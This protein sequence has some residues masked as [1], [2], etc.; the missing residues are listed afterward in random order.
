MEDKIKEWLLKGG[1]PLEMRF[2]DSLLK[3]EFEVAQSVYYQ[4][5]DTDKFRETDIIASKY[6][7]INKIWTHIAFVIE[8]KKSTDKPWIVLK[9]DKVINH[10]G[11][12]L[13]VFKTRNCNEFIR[14][15]K[16]DNHY[17]SDLFFKN[18]RS[19]G[20]SVQTAFNNGT[21]K[22]FEAIQSVTKACEYF[23]NKLNERRNTAAFYFPVILIEGRLF[24][25]QLQN[26][27][28]KI[29]EVQN[30][31][32]LITRSFHKHGNSHLMIFDGSN[33][34]NV[35][36]KLNKLAESFFKEY[37]ETLYDSLETYSDY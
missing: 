21:D 8:C 26:K 36:D 17:K 1:F 11:D 29:E 4:D 7:R 12:E 5:E 27:E 22:S 32:V 19:I 18:D 13:P 15:L 37:E 3:K 6:K 2:T 34:D 9:N 33:L 28:V 30:S 20:Y 25:G 35:A 10:I 24:E 23:S 31:E 14:I 16:K